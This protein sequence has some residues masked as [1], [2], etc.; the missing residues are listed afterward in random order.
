MVV[1]VQLS[2]DTDGFTY[3]KWEGEQV[4][5]QGDWLVN[6]HG[7]VYTIDQQTFADTYKQVS[8]GL[9]FKP[10][11][12]WAE[13]AKNAGV[14]QTKEGSTSYVAGDYLVHNDE[15]GEDAYAVDRETFE[16]MYERVGDNQ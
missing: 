13:I 6:N 9:Y 15:A 3:H 8:K 4:C 1:A 12:V 10:E 16:A 5:K 14:V 2:V 7:D 11:P